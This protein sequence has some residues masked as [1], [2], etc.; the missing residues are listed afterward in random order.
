[1]MGAVDEG[2]SEGAQGGGWGWYLNC[3][4]EWCSLAADPKNQGYCVCRVVPYMIH[5]KEQ[6]AL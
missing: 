2:E 1:M 3:W 6:H 4:R 5:T